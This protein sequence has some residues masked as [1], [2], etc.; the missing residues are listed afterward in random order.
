VSANTI[1]SQSKTFEEA[2][3]KRLP[4]LGHPD[5]Q[6]I[7]IDQATSGGTGSMLEALLEPRHHRH[8][9]SPGLRP[10]QRTRPERR[11]D[12]APDLLQIDPQGPKSLLVLVAEEI[13]RGRGPN[14][15]RSACSAEA[16]VTPR[17]DSTRLAGVSVRRSNPSCR[18]SVPSQGCRS[19]AAS[20]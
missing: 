13:D 6:V 1:C 3:G 7:R 11:L 10:L 20:S 9:S 17:L 14:S 15:S 12:P 8:P 19:R 4:D 16:A 2:N 18:C 5:Q